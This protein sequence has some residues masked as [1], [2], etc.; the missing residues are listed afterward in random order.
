[1]SSKNQN[2]LLEEKLRAEGLGPEHVGA[3]V[4]L[5]TDWSK[6]LAAYK[7]ST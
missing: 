5:I 7:L 6:K 1:M 2:H 3:V 4:K